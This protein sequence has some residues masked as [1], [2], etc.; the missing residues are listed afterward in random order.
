MIM[1]TPLHIAI[2]HGYYDAMLLL[3]QLGADPSKKDMLGFEAIHFAAI[4]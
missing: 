4:R 3:L 2:N 1:S